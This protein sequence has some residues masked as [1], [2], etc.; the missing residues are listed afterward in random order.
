M[1]GDTLLET[2]QSDVLA[3]LK[4]CPELTDANIIPEDAGDM[5]KTIMQKLGT[6]TG[7]GTS[8]PGL[9]IVVLLPKIS[10][11][12]INVP[13]P[14][15]SMEIEIRVIEQPLI[16][17]GADGT[18]IRSSVAALRVLA[19]L[20]LRSLGHCALR[21]LPKPVMPEPIKPGFLSHSVLMA[22]DNVGIDPPAKC[23]QV[24]AIWYDLTQ[25]M[26][27]SCPTAQMEIWYTTDGSYPAPDNP[28]ATLY[29]ALIPCDTLA[30]PIGTVIRAAAY[31]ADILPGDLT[32]VTV[33]E[34]L[35]N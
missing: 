28:T 33:T 5:D 21:P 1:T 14:P 26:G 20:Q 10:A 35:P 19:A 18:G 16:N 11:A 7:G 31:A 6:L 4:N 34:T 25:S 12:E 17:R 3:V 24:T 30:I 29:T 23:G 2:L 9:V 22:V 27:L 8:K 13:G 32:E 15:V